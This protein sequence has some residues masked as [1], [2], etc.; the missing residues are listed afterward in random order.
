MIYLRD[1]EKSYPSASSRRV[2]LK[3]TSMAIPTNRA[4]AILGRN[5]AGK[6]TLL[7]LL[8]GVEPPDRG[9]IIRD[10]SISWPIGFGGAIHSALTGRQNAE[11]VANLHGADPDEVVAFVEDFSELG[12][13]FD[14][15]V[16]TYSSGMR[17]RLNFALSFAIDFDC[18][19]VDEATATGDKKFRQK[20]LEAFRARRQ[21]SGVLFISHNPNVVRQY[22]EMGI[23]LRDGDLIPF[24]DLEDAI[25][26]YEA[27]A[28]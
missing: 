28:M 21:R 25:R 23:V 2:I 3:S 20:S 17:A 11:F 14:M 4:V 24:E 10:A 5:G 22:C 12:D 15:E 6:S 13:Y 16:S 7:R 1:V 27:T 8:A 9:E 26:F 19:L 18:Y